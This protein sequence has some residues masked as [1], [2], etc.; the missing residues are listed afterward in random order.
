MGNHWPYAKLILVENLHTH[1]G[2]FMSVRTM[3]ISA[4]F[5][6]IGC[7]S[8]QASIDNSLN[9]PSSSASDTV[10]LMAQNYER[11]RLDELRD[12]RDDR[13]DELR[14]RRDDLEDDYYDELSCD[15]DEDEC[16]DDCDDD[17]E[18]CYDDCDDFHDDCD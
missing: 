13:E 17:D 7:V 2:V 16:Y 4:L 5:L 10:V 9:V 12:R 3:L 15:D 18:D 6:A 1:R 14:D 8:V 11:D